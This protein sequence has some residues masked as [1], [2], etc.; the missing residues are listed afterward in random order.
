MAS[1][2]VRSEDANSEDEGRLAARVD[3]APLEGYR[4]EDCRHFQ[5]DAISWVSEWRD[6]RKVAALMGRIIRVHTRLTNG[7]LFAIRGNFSLMTAHEA[8]LYQA[9]DVT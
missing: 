8:K 2:S 9:G 3:G 4:F 7:R 6:G 5:G 1:T